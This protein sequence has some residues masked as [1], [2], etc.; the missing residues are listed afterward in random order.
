MS[1]YIVA[2]LGV[3]GFNAAL[4]LAER[5]E[6]VLAI[7]DKMDLVEEI[8]DKVSHAV[9][10]DTTDEKALNSLGLKDFDAAIVGIGENF[11]AN[12]LT[13]VLLKSGGVKKVISR[14]SNPIHTKILKAAGIDEVITPGI[15]AAEKVVFSLLHR[16]LIDIIYVDEKLSVAKI[17]ATAEFIGNSIGKLNLRAKY[18]I[19]VIAIHKAALDGEGASRDAINNP[20]AETVIQKGD[21]LLVV[22]DT[23][24]LE[25]ITRT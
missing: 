3:F 19:N 21:L 24:A 7:D 15:E 17:E 2:G 18:G 20:G 5:G 22:G 10:L 12:L 11:E 13:C 25:A 16:N 1:K 4:K 6:D 8:Q 23:D 14:S 9:C